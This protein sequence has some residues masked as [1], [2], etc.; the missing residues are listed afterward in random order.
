MALLQKHGVRY[1]LVG[2]G[3]VIYY[4]FPRLTG[5]MDFFYDASPD[6]ARRLYAALDDFW[7]GQIP[8][9]NK[10]D[11][12]TEPGLILQ[13]GVPPNRID[14][15]NQIDGVTFAEVWPQRLMLAMPFGGK[16]VEVSMIGLADLIRNKEAAQRPK[17]LDDLKFLRRALQ[18]RK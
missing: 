2:G 9:L 15:I 1:L 11:E 4:G 12:L 13:F 17:D 7:S 8:N 14:L 6:N 10:Q 18:T 5:D 3:A 16:T